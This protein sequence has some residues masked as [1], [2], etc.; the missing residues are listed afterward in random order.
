MKRFI[1]LAALGSAL[2][3]GAEPAR[4]IFDTDMYTDFDDAEA[5]K[6]GDNTIEDYTIW[7][8]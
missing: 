5:V 8:R 3:L 1:V 7:M 4:V 6:A 2:A